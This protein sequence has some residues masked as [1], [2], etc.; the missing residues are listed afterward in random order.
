MMLVMLIVASTCCAP[1]TYGQIMDFGNV[2]GVAQGKSP[3]SSEN[4]YYYDTLN[5][6]HAQPVIT[7]PA[8]QFL[9]NEGDNVVFPCVVTNLGEYNLIWR[10]GDKLLW[11]LLEKNGERLEQ[12]MT[13]GDSRL[14][15]EGTALSL[16]DVQGE[17]AGSYTCEISSKPP[18]T[19]NHTLDVRVPPAVFP[20]NN[21]SVVTVKMGSSVTIA[22]L[23]YGKPRPSITWSLKGR[24][25]TRAPSGN[26]LVVTNAQPEDNGMYT[27]TADNGAPTTAK[28]VITLQVMFPPKVRVEEEEVITG[29]SYSATLACFVEAEPMAKVNW[30]RK[31]DIPVDPLRLV[32]KMDVR[33]RYSL[34][35]DMVTLE[36]FGVYT[37]NATN[38]MGNS[39]AVI[40]LTGRPKPVRY[41]S[42]PQG[43]ENTTYTLVWDVESYAPVLT[44]TISY[45]NESDPEDQWVNLMVPGTSSSSSLHSSSHTFDNLQPG[46]TYNVQVTATNEFGES[47]VNETFA[48]STLREAGNISPEGDKPT[49]DQHPHP[50]SHQS[51]DVVSE[52]D[53]EEEPSQVTPIKDAATVGTTDGEGAKPTLQEPQV[54]HDGVATA[55][56]SASAQDSAAPTLTP[57]ERR[58]QM[59]AFLTAIILSCF[60]S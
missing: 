52:T 40:H 46:A 3:W 57:A 12:E 58:T 29:V 43:D 23:P 30:Y 9:I 6:E 42:S 36:D 26:R 10:H 1:F 28:A 19:L 11:I 38:Y 56:S 5:P 24:K 15:L 32:K 2:L 31:G 60:F 59:G 13:M 34:Q 47:D 54:I 35:F 8:Q 48:F 25:L 22:C 53:E 20:A 45:G 17:D 18:R 49:G 51:Q 14:S 50:P 44:Y 37:C 7:S 27:C 16:R 39:S 55:E 33:R 41:F 4:D 21:R